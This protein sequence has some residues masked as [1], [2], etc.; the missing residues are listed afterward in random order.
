MT[1]EA[2]E[3]VNKADFTTLSVYQLM[4]EEFNKRP[5]ALPSKH[6]TIL[7]DKML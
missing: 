7:V 1:S 6:C 4:T 2:I 3:K 5:L